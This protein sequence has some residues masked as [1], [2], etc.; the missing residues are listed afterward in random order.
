MVK[1]RIASGSDAEGILAIYSPFILYSAAS[2]ETRVPDLEEF[3]K[4]IDH[5]LQKYPWL[6]CTINGLIAGYVYASNYRDREAYQWSCECSVYVHEQYRGRGIGKELYAVLFS[7]LQKQ[8][9][10]TVYAG[11]TLPNDAS[12]K[13]HEKFG[14]KLLAV[15]ENV[16]YK[17]GGWK[18]VGWWRLQLNNY[19]LNPPPPLSFLQMDPQLLLESFNTAAQKIQASI[20]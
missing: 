20:I 8:G 3:K 18:S 19:D 9:F 10:R 14:F 16:G 1:I 7:I 17:L 11:I 13:V 2:F 12:I 15:Y 4:R 5:Y 6:V